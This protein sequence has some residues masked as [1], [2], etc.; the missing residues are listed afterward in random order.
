MWNITKSKTSFIQFHIVYKVDTGETLI[1]S[2]T[3]GQNKKSRV[4]LQVR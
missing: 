1:T 2:E 4:Q 3:E